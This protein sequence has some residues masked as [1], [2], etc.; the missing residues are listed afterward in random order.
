MEELFLSSYEK[1]S[2]K[3]NIYKWNGVFVNGI[4]PAISIDKGCHSH[5]RL[6]PSSVTRWTLRKLRAEKNTCHLVANRLQ[7]LRRWWALR[8]FRMWKYRILAPDSR[9]AYQRNEFSEPG[10]LHLPIQRKALNSL[11]WDIW[12]S[13]INNNLFMFRLPALCYKTSI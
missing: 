10:I 13:L 8:K 4:F 11:T 5:Q 2:D 3:W 6:K 7:P 9:G 1:E 12:F